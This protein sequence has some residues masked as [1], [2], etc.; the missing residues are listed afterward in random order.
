MSADESDLT[1]IR[2]RLDKFE[3][4]L[5]ANIA[6]TQAMRDEFRAAI[7]E[8]RLANIGMKCPQ[9]G[10]CVDLAKQLEE[11]EE[12]ITSMRETILYAKGAIWGIGALGGAVGGAVAF[13]VGLGMDFIKS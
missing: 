9:P 8:M 10:K 6:A 12:K 2:Y 3:P 5:D 7:T 13:V 11:H 4:K 1:L